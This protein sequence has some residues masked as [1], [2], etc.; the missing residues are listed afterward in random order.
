MEAI[1]TCWGNLSKNI[2]KNIKYLDLSQFDN[3][4]AL[5]WSQISKNCDI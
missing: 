2:Q 1:V 3:L 5:K 4:T